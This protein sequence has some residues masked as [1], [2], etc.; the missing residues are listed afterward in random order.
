M[1]QKK[2]KPEGWK[3]KGITPISIPRLGA[4]IVISIEDTQHLLDL[5]ISLSDSWRVLYDLS[6]CPVENYTMIMEKY[7]GETTSEADIEKRNS[8]F[9]ELTANLCQNLTDQAGVLQDIITHQVL[10][11]AKRAIDDRTK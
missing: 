6:R 8:L 4:P 11:T 1:G 7:L 5:V 10:L 9:A 3:P 2:N